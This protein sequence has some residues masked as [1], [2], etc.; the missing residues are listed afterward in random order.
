M[1]DEDERAAVGRERLEQD[2]LRVEVEVVRR[3][4]EQQHVR[5]LEQHLREREPVALA[6]REH[7]DLLEDVVAREQEAAQDRADHVRHRQRAGRRHLL[8]HGARRVQ[9]LGLVLREVV[10]DHVVAL[11]ADALV[12][13]VDAG[14]DPH[15]RRL[16]GAVRPDERDAVAALDHQVDVPQDHVLA[17]RLAHA[18]ELEHDAARALRLGELEVDLLAL[19]RD[20]DPLDLVE[21]LDPALDLLGLRRLVAEA[22]DEGLGLLDL[23]ALAAVRLAQALHARRVL[24]QVVAVVAVVVGQRL[25]ADL[26]DA[27]DGRVEEVAVVRDE[28]HRAGVVGQV[29][30]EPVARRQVEVVR[31]LVHQQQVRP[32]QQQLGERD[33]HLPAA[34]ELLRPALVVGER[35]AEPLQHVRD[36]GVDLVAA[37]V[38]E[39]LGHLGVALEQLLVAAR[40]LGRVRELRPRSGAAR[41]CSASSSVKASTTSSCTVRPSWTMPSCGR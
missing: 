39:A 17:V 21:Q 35:E 16:A 34:R 36:A 32:R 1:R 25:E 4:V 8:V 27:L 22:V 12:G 28:H 14:E 6:A 2:L 10:E 3:L 13:A 40:V 38:L 24:A 31:R 7:R 37:E 41:P 33:A 20:L 18:L 11:E 26:G 19:G 30:L 15:Q 23:L 9:H 29:L 5:G